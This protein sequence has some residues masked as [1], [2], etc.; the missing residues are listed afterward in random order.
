MEL[1]VIALYALVAVTVCYIGYRFCSHTKKCLPYHHHGKAVHERRDFVSLFH[2]PKEEQAAYAK[3][4]PRWAAVG[5][6]R[7]EHARQ[8]NTEQ[9]LGMC[10]LRQ[11]EPDLT[12][13]A[14]E[15]YTGDFRDWVKA[16][17]REEQAA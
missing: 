11:I 8:T 2:R 15:Y 9:Y 1:S 14:P 16:S 3:A 12:G 4:N 5:A 13:P 17:H 7:L 6:F 10:E